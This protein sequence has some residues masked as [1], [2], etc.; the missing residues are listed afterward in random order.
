MLRGTTI[1]EPAAH[2]GFVIETQE[3]TILI[4]E[5]SLARANASLLSTKARPGKKLARRGKH[6]DLPATTEFHKEFANAMI[7]PK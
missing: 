5:T 2:A 7:F 1:L 4:P 6:V 3:I